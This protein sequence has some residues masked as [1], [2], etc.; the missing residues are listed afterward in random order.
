MHL[1]FRSLLNEM[2]KIF[3]AIICILVS[4]IFLKLLFFYIIF[5]LYFIKV[6]GNNTFKTESKEKIPKCK[7]LKE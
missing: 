5:S 6:L 2:I 4:C 7:I 3:I 1:C